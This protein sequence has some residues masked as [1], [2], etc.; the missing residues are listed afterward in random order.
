MAG[1]NGLQVL[2]VA[3]QG[4]RDY[5]LHAPRRFSPPPR[6]QNG[7]HGWPTLEKQAGGEAAR[8]SPFCRAL[9]S[10]T[11]AHF[12]Q[13]LSQFGFTTCGNRRCPAQH[14]ATPALPLPVD[15][16]YGSNLTTFEFPFVH[17]QNDKKK[18][19]VVE[20][21][22][23]DGCAVLGTIAGKKLE[24]PSALTT[25]IESVRVA[26][27]RLD[28]RN[29]AEENMKAIPAPPPSPPPILL[30]FNEDRKPIIRY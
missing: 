1:P 22:L 23:C 24:G 12:P 30:A 19:T 4:V 13:V 7:T 25:A 9:Y 5:R 11:S 20:V 26:R 28:E 27:N 8:H 10:H 16:K 17:R 29:D 6:D 14:P 3:V 2:A 18:F 15:L 21:R